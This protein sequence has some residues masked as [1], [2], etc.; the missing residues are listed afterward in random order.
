MHER[1][2]SSL[3]CL[4][5]KW[6]VETVVDSQNSAGYTITNSPTRMILW[7]KKWSA[8]TAHPSQQHVALQVLVG[9]AG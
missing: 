1:E 5:I 4:E 7:T 9:L 8:A 6:V 3:I 2:A